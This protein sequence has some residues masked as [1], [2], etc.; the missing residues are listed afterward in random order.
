M[1]GVKL[2]SV[3]SIQKMIFSLTSKH[4]L[5]NLMLYSLSRNLKL[6][7]SKYLRKKTQMALIQIKMM[8]MRNLRTLRLCC[9]HLHR[10][11][12]FPKYVHV[13]I[14]VQAFLPLEEVWHIG[15]L[16]D[17]TFPWLIHFELWKKFPTFRKTLEG[18]S[19]TIYLFQ[20]ERILSYDL[21]RPSPSI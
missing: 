14:C 4:L 21:Y 10:L 13:S 12:L 19:L 1:H 9:L 11:D 17:L 18:L 5:K 15:Q 7:G 20:H 2:S 8:D 16:W 3:F 6:I